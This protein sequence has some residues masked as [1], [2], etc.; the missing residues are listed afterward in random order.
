M[1]AADDAAPAMPLVAAAEEAIGRAHEAMVAR[2]A[3]ARDDGITSWL[4][5]FEAEHAGVLQQVLPTILAHPDMPPM[6]RDVLG[7][8]ADPVHQ[9]QVLLGL[10]SVGSIVSGFVSAAISPEVQA[11]SNV[12]WSAN[13]DV[14]L[15]PAEMALA[16]LRGHAD[17]DAGI[18]ES[19]MSGISA[20]R[21]DLLIANTGEPPGLQQLQEALRRGII[22]QTTFAKGV[23]QSRVRNEWIDTLEALR[24]A[25]VPVGE[26]LAAVVQG[27]ISQ[28]EA[29][30]R[31][32][33]AGLNPV[34]FPWLYETHGRPPGIFELLELVN[35]GE[36]SLADAEQAIR[37]SDIK[38]KY[39][40][41]LAKLRRKIPPMRSV[42]AMLHQGV[43]TPAEAINKLR[44]LGY[45]EADAAAF[46]KE[47]AA[48]RHAGVKALS[49][50]QIHAAYAAR[51]ITRAK[52]AT[53]LTA[54][55]Y[56]ATE[57]EMLLALADHERH[58]KFQNSAISRV[59]TRYVAHRITRQEAIGALGKIGVDPTG[60]DDLMA[61]WDDE[62]AANTPV[63][64]LAQLDGMIH[65]GLITQAVY[66][67]HVLALGYPLNYV[68]LLYALAFPPTKPG[69][70]W[71]L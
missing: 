31:L 60:R 17:V 61:L 49:Q 20:S 18:R 67:Q 71:K 45:D 26:V 28:A 63:L 21:F 24:Y 3:T 25:P 30:H 13:A 65:R 50:S 14:P 1:A 11:V 34:D 6:V 70:E 9:T 42:V 44:Q 2:S 58:A 57:V 47:G 53:M 23:R 69:P 7:K 15:S 48:S 39:I 22:D 29:A 38:N 56:D 5:A 19:A 10:V 43:I 8:I 33:V 55:G 27:H 32:D 66:Q 41:A 54:L 52:A 37:E 40:P 64:T 12:A 36:Y 46:A 51:M 4:E 59:H 35:R 68:P 62:R 16:V